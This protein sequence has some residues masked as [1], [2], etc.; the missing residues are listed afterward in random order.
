MLKKIFTETLNADFWTSVLME[1]NG[2]PLPYLSD[3]GIE[4]EKANKTI[5]RIAENADTCEAPAERPFGVKV[6]RE[7]PEKSA[8]DA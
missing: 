5:A 1:L 7:E 6:V 2:C 8:A 4:N 3:L